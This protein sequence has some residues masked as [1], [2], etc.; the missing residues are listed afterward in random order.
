MAQR[1]FDN[2]KLRA[3]YNC[4]VAAQHK[5]QAERVGPETPAFD[6][7]EVNNNEVHLNAPEIL[8]GKLLVG[9]KLSIQI[10]SVSYRGEAIVTKVVPVVMEQTRTF[11]VTAT[12]KNSDARV[13]PGLFAEAHMN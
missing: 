10:P 11:R 1:N 12:L 8:V 9:N 6:L 5:D 13:V 2:T 4:V 7:Y 3:P